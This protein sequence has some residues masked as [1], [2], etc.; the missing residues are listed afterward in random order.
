MSGVVSVGD[1]ERPLEVI[2]REI[3][4]LAAHVNAAMCRWLLLVGE[5]DRRRGWAVWGAKSCAHWL[6]WRCALSLATGRD[7]VGVARALEG[8]PEVREAFG[9]GRLSYSKV[10]ALVRVATADTE[11]VLLETA[12]CLSAS[13]LERVVRGMRQVLDADGLSSAEVAERRHTS[14]RLRWRWDEDGCLVFSVAWRPMTAPG[15]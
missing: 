8:L 6:N 5:F 10:R 4:E 3:T 12:R 2:E 11:A 13:Q 15:S 14:R 1:V 7:Q 9:A